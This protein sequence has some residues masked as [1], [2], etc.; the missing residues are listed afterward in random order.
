M[1]RSFCMPDALIGYVP[2]PHFPGASAFLSNIRKFKTD[3][4]LILFSDHP[5][6]GMIHLK[7]SPE[8]ARSQKG[9]AVS[10]IIWLTALK[11]LRERPI[12][13]FL[14]LEADCR[15]K[16]DYW[17]RRIFEEVKQADPLVA[18]TLVCH[19]MSNKNLAWTKLWH[20]FMARNA[21]G[22]FP[23]HCYG[24]GGATEAREPIVFANGALGVY[25]LQG[26]LEA[27]QEGLLPGKMLSWS[28]NNTAWDVAV[29][30]SFYR[31]QG[32]SVFHGIFMHLQ[33]IY[34]GFGNVQTTEA[35]RAEFL[36]S[37][38]VAAVHQIKSNWEP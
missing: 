17:D 1:L 32:E 2:P 13:R 11:I 27:F 26:M 22:T 36:S 8:V 14:Y 34:S 31:T 3:N 12:E 7:A 10:N 20:D 24:N 33:S 15:V 18:G 38:R 9:W 28:V 30:Q 29:G 19:S 4:E 21:G 6:D 37:G 25:H 16:G 23:I 5:Y 35:E